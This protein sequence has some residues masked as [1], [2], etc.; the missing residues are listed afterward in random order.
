MKQ[1]RRKQFYIIHSWVGVLSGVLMFVVCFSGAVA[2]FGTPEL[3][4]WSN[5]VNHQHQ[6]VEATEIERLLREHG[7]GLDA[8]YR[9]EASIILPARLRQQN[10]VFSFSADREDA[11]GRIHHHSVVFEHDPNTLKL[12]SRKEGS[13]EQLYNMRDR[14][15]ADFITTFHA[16]LHLGAPWG[17]I[18]TGLLGLALFASIVTGVFIHRKI[19]KE[20]FSFRPLRSLRLMWVDSHKVIGVWGILFHS[21]IAFSGAYLGLAAVVLIPAAAFVSFEGD[22]EALVAAVLPD[23]HPELTGKQAE[24]QLAKV[25]DQVRHSEAGAIIS[26]SLTGWRDENAVVIVNTLPGDGLERVMLEYAATSGEYVQRHTTYGRIGGFSGPVMDVLRP[27]HFGDFGGLLV[28]GLWAVL[29]LGTALTGLSGMMIWVERRAYGPV[30]DLST[31]QYLLMSRLVIGVCLGMV[32][33]VLALFYG[34]R[35]LT[36]AGPAMGFWLGLVFF[37]SWWVSCCWA[38]YCRNEY[39]AARQLSLLAG[40]MAMGLPVLSGLSTGNHLLNVFS[41]GHYIVAGVDLSLLL[42][43]LL[44]WQLARRMPAS[45]PL[46]GKRTRYDLALETIT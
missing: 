41:G 9:H 7:E 13:P 1:R 37:A 42:L 45:R 4:V 32:V 43:G 24:F 19:L 46:R 27:L 6:Q 21:V 40:W 5:P 22:Q 26:V 38:L 39:Q 2:V 3:K 11:K 30:G 20:L 14:D 35:L 17:L 34:Q 36:V 15:A 10:L 25:I 33:A 31:R 8:D 29:G 44:F 16:D 12:L 28:K 18:V 23:I